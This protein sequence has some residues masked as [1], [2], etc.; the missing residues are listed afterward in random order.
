MGLIAVKNGLK[1]LRL[2]G[3]V[4]CKA[5][6]VHIEK[7]TLLVLHFPLYSICLVA[8]CQDCTY[9]CQ[10]QAYAVGWALQR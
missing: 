5:L 7:P 4:A 2:L 9:Q 3:K 10:V 1:W 8:W 6:H